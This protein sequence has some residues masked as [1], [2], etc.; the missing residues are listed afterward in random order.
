MT[1]A[2]PRRRTAIA[3]VLSA[4]L[5]AAVI[6]GATA[7]CGRSS[8][9]RAV[10]DEGP[11]IRVRT[12]TA[13][14]ENLPV[15]VEA[16]GT[17]RAVERA[18]LAAKVMG[19]IEEL[20]VRLGQPVKKGD[21]IA[22]ISAAEIAA[23]ARQAQSN[24]DG[25]RRDLAR[26]SEL[27]Q[28]GAAPRE[29]V[30]SLKDRIKSAEAALKEAEVMLGYT[31]VRAPFDGAVARRMADA[32]DLASPGVPLVELEGVGHYEIEAE[33]PESAA[34]QLKVGR[35]LQV[36]V[37]AAAAEFEARITEVAAAADPRTRTVTIKLAVPSDVPARSGQFAR[38]QV[39]GAPR[40]AVLVPSSAVSTIGQIERAFVVGP[41]NRLALRLV[42]TGS[43]TREN[44]EI[45]AGLN[46]GERVVGAPAPSLRDGQRVE[47][48]P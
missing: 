22:R 25:L 4:A 38:I 6:A 39:P 26:E 18:E 14:A 13:R 8:P 45:L 46:P 11:A 16:T 31:A 15:L 42:K 20:P 34:T 48:E 21:L 24:L 5:A 35:A 3:R 28:K 29:A 19:V 30:E 36:T 9:P 27:L 41:E 1:P 17:V 32:G 33:V 7:G 10:Q 44:V 37:P 47:I 23:R 40:P 43:V 12:A 2:L